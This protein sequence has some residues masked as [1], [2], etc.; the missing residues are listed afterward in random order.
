MAGEDIKHSTIT[1]GEIGKVIVFN[2]KVVPQSNVI[3]KHTHKGNTQLN[4]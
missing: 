4:Q 1:N 3:W 2:V